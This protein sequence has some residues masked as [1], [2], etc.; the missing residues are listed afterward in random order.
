M[1]SNEIK[2]LFAHLFEVADDTPFEQVFEQWPHTPL[3]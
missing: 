3:R 1:C 2:T